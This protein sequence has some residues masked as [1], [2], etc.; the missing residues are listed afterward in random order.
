[1]KREEVSLIIDVFTPETLPMSRLA[2][3]LRSFSAMLGH[4]ESIH[5][6]KVEK[7][8]ADCI[9]EIETVAYPKVQERLSS[10]VAGDAPRS[11]LEAHERIDD[12]LA[13][14]NAIGFVKLGGHNVIEF[15]GRRRGAKEVIGPVARRSSIEGQIFSIG[16]KDETI[17]VHLK[18]GERELRCVVSIS[19]ARDLGPHLR[20]GRLRLFGQGFWSRVDGRWAMKTFEADSFVVLD[21]SPL[22]ATLSSIR[23]TFAQVN[24]D[25]FLET[26]LELRRD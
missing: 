8:S 3:Y 21:E 14:D 5:F 23:K 7:G 2:E 25:E 9:A 10:V 20:G 4:E 18:D 17:N 22:R 12:L 16:G 26:T 11:A 1:M 15:P 24:P 6:K 19:L 13:K